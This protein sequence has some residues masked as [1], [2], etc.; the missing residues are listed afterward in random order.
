[1]E[2]FSCWLTSALVP[3]LFVLL[4]GG[5]IF[6][7][8]R[9][10]SVIKHLHTLVKNMYRCISEILNIM[11]MFI[12]FSNLFQKAKLI[13]SRFITHEWEYYIRPTQKKRIYNTQILTLVKYITFF[14]PHLLGAP[15]ITASVRRGMEAIR[16]WHC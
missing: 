9:L 14:T 11:E 7:H 12:Y 15:L 16:L 6:F 2:S 3:L 4:Y 8:H 5:Q 10:T 1:M 13:Y